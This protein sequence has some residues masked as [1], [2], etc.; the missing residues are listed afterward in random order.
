MSS[1]KSKRLKVKKNY[2][3]RVKEEQGE[4]IKSK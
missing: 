3:I 2:L 4:I 1:V